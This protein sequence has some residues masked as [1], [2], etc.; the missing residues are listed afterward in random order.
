VRVLRG[1]VGSVT[2]EFAILV[3]F[4]I[5]LT[6]FLFTV[7]SY[8]LKLTEMSAISH[9]FARQLA[10][11]F[12][13]A[14]TQRLYEEA[15]PN[16]NFAVDVNQSLLCTLVTEKQHQQTLAGLFSNSVKPAK[17]CTFIYGY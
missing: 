12:S 14:E 6:L 7:V 3:P 17:T 9:S 15:F 10:S 11:G 13:Q 4:L 2:A 1:E 5:A 8:P 16:Y